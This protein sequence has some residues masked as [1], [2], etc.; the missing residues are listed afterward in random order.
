MPFGSV[1]GV[2]HAPRDHVH[3][4]GSLRDLNG[5][6]AAQRVDLAMEMMQVEPE[7][8]TDYLTRFLAETTQISRLRLASANAFTV[9][10]SRSTKSSTLT[11][12]CGSAAAERRVSGPIPLSARNAPSRSGSPATKESA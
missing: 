11:R 3:E 9:W 7:A 8:L 6:Q 4:G 5:D 12:N 10:S 2:D 1:D